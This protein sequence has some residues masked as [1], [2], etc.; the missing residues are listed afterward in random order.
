MRKKLERDFQS[1]KGTGDPPHCPGR[2]AG[3]APGT[4]AD[5]PAPPDNFQDQ[6]KR[7]LAYREEM[8]QQLQIVRG[9]A[10]P[11]A[12]IRRLLILFCISILSLF[13]L[14]FLTQKTPKQT[15]ANDIFW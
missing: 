2:G 10:R 15:K 6:M 1:L 12:A 8:V 13:Y 14:F 3:P 5:L 4:G 7:E 11:A 9:T